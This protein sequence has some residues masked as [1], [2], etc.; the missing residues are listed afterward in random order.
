MSGPYAQAAGDYW[1]N[2]WRGV[3][4]LP[5]RR[6]KEPPTGFTGWSGAY[7][8]YPDVMAWV[9]D[10]GE[11]NIALHLPDG[12]LGIDVDEYDGKVGGATL[13]RYEAQWGP[14]PATWLTTSRDNVS[15]IRLFRVPVAESGTS[16][17][18]PSELKPDI[19]LVHRGHRYM[20]VPPSI[21]PDTGRAY[22]WVTPD[23]VTSTVGPRVAEL[24][25]LPWAWV[26][27]LTQGREAHTYTGAGMDEAEIKAWLEAHN[28]GE[29][30]HRMADAVDDALEE[31]QT[32]GHDS[33]RMLMRIVGAAATGHD[34]LYVGLTKVRAAFIAEVTPRR[35]QGEREAASEWTRSLFGAVDKVVGE[36]AKTGTKTSRIDPC[37][38]LVSPAPAT[39]NASTDILSGPAPGSVDD[40]N[41]PGEGNDSLDN[42]AGDEPSDED[43]PRVLTPEE[44]REMAITKAMHELG[45][46]R[47]ARRRLE[48][49]DAPP[50]EVLGAHAFL[51]APQPE[52]VVDRMLYKDSLARIYGRPGCGKSFLSL[53]LAFSVALGRPWGGKPVAQ[54][55]VFYVMAEGQRVNTR[56]A[57]AWL[58]RNGH[59][60]DELEG[61]F[62]AV[63]HKVL[64]T[65]EAIKPFVA[66]VAEH[67]AA[68][69]IFDTKNAMM[70]GDENSS[71]DFASMRYALDMVREATDACVVLIDHT[72]HMAQD[73]A[74][75]TSAG[76]AGM[77]TEVRVEN[78]GQSPPR[79]AITVTRDKADEA[80]MSWEFMLRVHPIDEERPP[81]VLVPL[82]EDVELPE[83]HRETD[84][85][86]KDG[87]GVVVPTELLHYEGPGSTAMPD[88]ARYMASEASPRA[89]DP[90]GVGRSRAE[91]TTALKEAG[92]ARTTVWR[93]WSALIERGDID[94][95]AGCKSDTGRHVWTA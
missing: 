32:G 34:G 79:I 10:R 48:A 51:T 78:D 77:D 46:K 50:L 15:G 71:E 36:M 63:P 73:R 7:P 56:R 90:N 70:V 61:K 68:L 31:L 60:A 82:G 54:G 80:G 87:D 65:E 19:Q 39:A 9:E 69:V 14:L 13:A 11:G 43:A 22:R 52:P 66:A 25:E 84:L 41:G 5:P 6:K 1:A 83:R 49:E 29:P 58:D 62:F 88:L 2:G 55:P 72:G 27:G 64:L 76:E 81:A 67:K 23:G 93:A 95:A 8:S 28:H 53:D 3:L 89:N 30:C 26:V 75:G 91:A 20:V 24:P 17:G 38:L 16:L 40:A 45:V 44:R 33:L 57:L 92:H 86:W 18:W 37:E 42:G 94:R 59:R 12:V 4:P 74:R 85:A 35:E 21:H 47:E